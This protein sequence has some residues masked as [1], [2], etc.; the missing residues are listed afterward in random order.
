MSIRTRLVL[1]TLV[2]ALIAF[3]SLMLALFSGFFFDDPDGETLAWVLAT[4]F[5][6]LPLT[7]VI[8][9]IG[10]WIAYARGRHARALLLAKLPIIHPIT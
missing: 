2:T 7:I 4:P 9:G 3:P 6:T 10:A 5:F 1:W 8:A